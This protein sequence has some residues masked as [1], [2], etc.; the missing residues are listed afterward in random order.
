MNV[1]INTLFLS[2]LYLL[3]IAGIVQIGDP[4][5][6]GRVVLKE[7]KYPAPSPNVRKRRQARVRAGNF[8]TGDS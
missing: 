8:L 1:F 2:H 4:P 3:C 7:K 6:W 5:P